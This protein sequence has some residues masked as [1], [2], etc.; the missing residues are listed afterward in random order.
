M[1]LS[2]LDV[3]NLIGRSRPIF[4]DAIA[5]SESAMCAE[6]KRSKFL[7]IGGAGTIG[8]AVVMEI[9]SRQP[10]LIDVVDIS[11]NN[12]VELVRDIR[13][14]FGSSGSDLR[15]LPLD[16]GSKQFDFFLRDEKIKYDYVLNL[17]AL[18]HV[19]SEKD[20]YSLMRMIEVNIFNALKLA[21]HAEQIGAKKYFSV[22]TDK[23]ANPV[24]LMGASK[25][26]MERFLWARFSSL[27][28]S[29]ARFANVAFSDG[30]LLHS[31]SQRFAKY[32]P[33]VV[34]GD[35]LRY[36]ISPKE[37][38][39]LCL[40]SAMFGKNGDIFF[41]SHDGELELTNFVHI[42]VRFLNSKGYGAEFCTTEI[43]ALEKKE[44]LIK[45]G[46]WPVLVSKSDTTGEKAF[47]EFY[48]SHENVIY[49]EMSGIG[50]V[51]DVN[52]H[53]LDDGLDKFERAYCDMVAS[54]GPWE[55]EAIVKFFKDAIP[56]LIYRDTGKNLDQKM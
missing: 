18:K 2:I 56:E 44:F 48:T 32:Q 24:N 34:P 50:I 29:M 21:R 15:C 47:E 19:R 16:V 53:Y 1:R 14:T 45:N 52:L 11:E 49:S 4:I 10:Q 9:Y 54:S 5:Q 55:K 33:I 3:F 35:V 26:L 27:N 28:I 41:P 12:L 13:C 46:R 20:P 43:E 42:A 36:F 38:G 6:I 30:S 37:A 51:R 22:S 23:A 8:Q 25:R 39:E 40:L 17:S 31:F 7:V